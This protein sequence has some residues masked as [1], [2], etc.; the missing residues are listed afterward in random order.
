M[1]QQLHVVSSVARLFETH[2]TEL[3]R[4]SLS[5]KQTWKSNPEVLFLHLPSHGKENK[6]DCRTN[7]RVL[8]SSIYFPELFTFLAVFS[9]ERTAVSN[10]RKAESFTYL[11]VYIRSVYFSNSG[12]NLK[13]QHKLVGNKLHAASFTRGRL[14]ST[15]M[16]R[17]QRWRMI[18]TGRLDCC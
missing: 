9:L 13:H 10:R 6:D 2:M 16:G 1:T 4:T 15:Y 7:F 8:I 17:C 14:A 5:V 11:L 18:I 3:D 12:N